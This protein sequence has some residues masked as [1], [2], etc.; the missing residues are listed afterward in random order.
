[1]CMATLAA[2][3]VLYGKLAKHVCASAKQGLSRA[4]A[5]ALHAPYSDAG[6]QIDLKAP[7]DHQAQLERRQLQLQ[8]CSVSKQA[9]QSSSKGTQ[10]EQNPAGN[11]L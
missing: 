4:Q 7:S 9:K 8:A 1:M 11:S 5:A 6:S 3:A 10:K 2:T